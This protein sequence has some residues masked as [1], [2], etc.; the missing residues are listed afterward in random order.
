MKLRNIMLVVSNIEESIK[1]YSEVFGLSVITQV[2][3]NAVLT[4]GLVLQDK[5]IWDTVMPSETIFRNNSCEIY[6]EE[7]D[8]EGFIDR[9]ICN[10]LLSRRKF[11]QE[12]LQTYFVFLKAS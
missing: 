2:E 6:F 12:P 1:Y 11:S 8:I 4:E 7:N 5:A 9:L 3:H 10:D